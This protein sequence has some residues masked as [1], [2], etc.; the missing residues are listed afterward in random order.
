MR[1]KGCAGSVAIVPLI[2]RP[3]GEQPLHM[4]AVRV[5]ESD[6]P[7]D[8]MLLDWLLPACDGKPEP[9]HALRIVS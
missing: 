8:A 7:A 2:D 4:L 6:P 9:E 5:L 1:L 3:R